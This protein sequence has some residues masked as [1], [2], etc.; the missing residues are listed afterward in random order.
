MAKAQVA[1]ALRFLR[2]L[3][4][5]GGG[6]NVT[7]PDLIR[8]FLDQRDE[9]AFAAIVQRHGPLVFA[10]CRRLL[11]SEQDAE[12]ALQA[13]FM[14]L[15]RKAG[16]LRRPELLANWLHGV[17]CRIARKA[18]AAADRRR[19]RERPLN[20]DIPAEQRTPET[21]W[22]DLRP[23]L[24]DEIGRLPEKYRIPFVL[25]Y[26]DHRTNQEAARLIGCPTG[27]VLSRLSWARERLRCRLSARGLAVSVATVGVVLSCEA[28][29]VPAALARSTVQAATAFAAGSMSTGL[30]S[31][32]VAELA[33]A[34]LRTV[35][36]FRL[37]MVASLLLTVFALGTWAALALLDRPTVEPEGQP[38][39][40][41]AEPPRRAPETAAKSADSKEKNSTSKD[42]AIPAEPKLRLTLGPAHTGPVYSVAYSPDGKML[43]SGS[44]DKTINLWDVASGNSLC[45]FETDDVIRNLAFSP[46]GKALVSGSNTG[47]I[48]QWDVVRRKRAFGYLGHTKAIWAI[49]FRPDG[50][51]FAS[52]S[53]D[54][55][56]RLWD[57]ESGE[58]TAVFKGHTAEVRTVAFSPDGKT[59][60]S[61]AG[62]VDKSIKLWDAASGKTVATL[63]GHT[64]FISSVTFSPD[65]KT[66]ASASGDECI[67]L[68]NV[69]T[70]ENTATLKGHSREV[71]HVAFA[72]DGKT[73]ASGSDDCSIKLWDVATSK[74][75][76]TLKGH[77][78][79]VQAVAFSPDGTTLAS[80][81]YDADIKFWDV[82]TGKNIATITGHYCSVAALAVSRDGKILASGGEHGILWLWDL[83]RGCQRATFRSEIFDSNSSLAFSPDGSKLASG[84]AS[85][86]SVRVWDVTLG[87]EFNT[88][89]TNSREYFCLAYS[90]DGKTLATGCA[91]KTVTLWYP[92]GDKTTILAGHA[93][94]VFSVAFSPD[95]K[96]LASG[97]DDKTIKL[98]DLADGNC[99]ATLHRH[100]DGV[101][102]VAFSPDGKML[103][104]ASKDG[105]ITLWT[106]ATRAHADTLRPDVNE[107]RVVAFSPDGK[108][109]ASDNSKAIELWDLASH[110]I[111]ATLTGHT[112]AVRCL[113][114]TPDGKTLI[115][116]SDDRTIKL[117]DLADS[118]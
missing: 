113:V 31:A 117:W 21:D 22:A 10:V 23:V 88:Y 101:Q 109:L 28:A 116:G 55:S 66:L 103:A 27:T 69:A 53:E 92:N 86:N 36:T 15:A 61:G 16:S 77:A 89:T 19:L 30:V 54:N 72:P 48:N 60:A 75:T 41:S 78:H 46:D 51:S 112:G 18:R 95:G 56:I 24:D 52:A 104:A 65:G 115:S 5:A 37:T 11:Y 91:D 49:A 26:L 64:S 76:A 93:G 80:G 38:G 12:D 74:N 94:G 47:K 42:S 2:C 33:Q 58:I 111:V 9:S 57:L 84:G 99:L 73:L 8:R 13:T 97:S 14:V 100:E 63:T 34:G 70:G 6:G 59:L 98:W 35:L 44:Q 20:M 29:P 107:V 32:N 85:H 50:K 90:P 68:W 118:R 83:N 81:G 3:G 67:K 82:A 45:T 102:S 17:A 96:L 108:T 62:W 71:I 105:T 4:G 43:A 106:V 40:T 87:K 110:K 1:F 79:W 39:P 7:E 25:C 114:F